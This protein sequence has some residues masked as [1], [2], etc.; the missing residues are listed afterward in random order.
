[1]QADSLIYQIEKQ[2]KDNGEKLPSDLKTKVQEKI[3]SLR[4]AV[5]SDDTEA[6]RKGIEALNQVSS[7]AKVI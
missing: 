3:D 4:E 1:M 7:T 6:M 2:L 5:N